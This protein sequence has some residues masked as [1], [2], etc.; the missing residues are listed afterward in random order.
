VVG[1]LRHLQQHCDLH[2]ERTGIGQAETRAKCVERDHG[3]FSGSGWNSS[4]HNDAE[5]QIY[6]KPDTQIDKQMTSDPTIL[7]IGSCYVHPIKE[8]STMAR[9]MALPKENSKV[10]VFWQ[11]VGDQLSQR[12][13]PRSLGT[14][15]SG[16]REFRVADVRSHM[17][18]LSPIQA[19]DLERNLLR[20]GTSTFQIW[21]LPTGAAQTLSKMETGDYFMTLDTNAEWGAFRYIGRVLYY[22]PGEHWN[23]SLHIW[24]ERKFP[25]IVLLRGIL[26]AYPWQRFL[27][28]FKYGEGLRPM[29]RTFRISEKSF[30]K[31]PCA[32]DAEFFDHIVS[33]FPPKTL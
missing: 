31:G 27:S 22:L 19:S 11:H 32:T 33:Q 8:L 30:A 14:P 9:S 13:F 29:G 10:S 23:L 1:E 4:K 6:V 26:V 28:D 3:T 12:D 21:G 20:I 15:Q 18:D 2:D 16:L 25:L 24:N 7:Q 17:S 5:G